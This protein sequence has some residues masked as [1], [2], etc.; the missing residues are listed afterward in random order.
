VEREKRRI[1]H[2]AFEP[3]PNIDNGSNSMRRGIALISVMLVVSA[4]LIRAD[5]VRLLGEKGKHTGT[6][7]RVSPTEVTIGGSIRETNIPVNEIAAVSFSL[8]PRG[9]ADA[10]EAYESGRY[11]NVISSL[12][13][14]KPEQIRRDE[15]KVEIEFYR[16]MAAAR[17]ASFGAVDQKTARAAGMDLQRL[18]AEHK[19]SYHFYEVNEALGDLLAAIKNPNANSFYDILAG[20]PWPEYKLRA[21]VLKG[22]ALQVQGNHQAAI[23]Q[24]D[25][26]LQGEIAG[27]AG[28]QAYLARVGKAVSLVEIGKVDDAMKLLAEV[29]DKADEGD[30]EVYA[31]AYN[32]LGGCYRKKNAPTEALLEYLK[33]DLLFNSVPD[34]HA[35]ALYNLSQLWND[36]RHPER[37]RDA[38]DRLKQRYATSRWNKS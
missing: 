36:E 26:A 13:D 37:A 2:S 17:M 3:F 24:F 4:S 34:A 22:R 7:Q 28:T 11:T 30:R 5:E 29:I 35:E 19:E 12:N 38:A 21:S 15:V 33:V 8:E 10:R 14:I 20:A 1:R 32:A 9:L 31:R 18:L 16:V 27:R 6:I 23:A 25:A